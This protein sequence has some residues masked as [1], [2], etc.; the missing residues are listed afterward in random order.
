MSKLTRKSKNKAIHRNQC[1]T[2]YS[3]AESI[4]RCW[5]EKK[6]MCCLPCFYL[7]FSLP[8]EVISV[9]FSLHSWHFSSQCLPRPFSS[10]WATNLWDNKPRRRSFSMLL[11][12]D[13][14]FCCSCSVCSPVFTDLLRNTQGRGQ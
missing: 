2:N 1:S 7:P 13:A 4:A 6:Y 12:P 8:H 9:L 11:Q 10:P 3:R 5:A 14:F